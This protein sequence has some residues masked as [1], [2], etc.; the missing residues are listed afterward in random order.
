MSALAATI[1]VSSLVGSVHCIAMCGPLVGM[2]GGAR[3]IRLALVHSLGRLVTYVALGTIA[4]LVGGAVDLAGDLASVQHVATIVSGLVIVGWG[5]HAIAVARGW[6][7]G[8]A[9]SGVL[10]QR[11]LVQLRGRRAVTRAAMIGVLT[12]FLP[13]GW[14][15]AFVVTAAG[16]GHAASGAL[17]MLVF[18]LGTVPAM[19]GVLAIAGPVLARMRA[20]LPVITACVLISLGLVTLASRWRDAGA[21]GVAAPHCHAGMRP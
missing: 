5:V 14:L 11:G 4:G 6:L 20:R 1:F 9:S 21:G 16:T 13:C 17:V 3:S 19:T 8:P 2:H 12:G 18:W 10:F 7:R 15:W